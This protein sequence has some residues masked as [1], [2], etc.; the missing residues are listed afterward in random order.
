MEH[1]F[2]R[3]SYFIISFAVLCWHLKNS[4]TQRSWHTFQAHFSAF[5]KSDPFLSLLKAVHD[6][7]RIFPLFHSSC[8]YYFSN[9]DSFVLTPGFSSQYSLSSLPYLQNH[10]IAEVGRH[11]GRLSRPTSLAKVGST[12]AGCSGPCPVR[13]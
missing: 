9:I 6:P 8:Q 1:H 5:S 7:H 2:G 13:C 4:D 12:G 11:L 10:T 3:M